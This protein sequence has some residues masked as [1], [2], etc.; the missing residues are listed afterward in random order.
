MKNELADR[1]EKKKKNHRECSTKRQRE[2]RHEREVET[3]YRMKGS[4]LYC[5]ERETREN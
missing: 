1:F 3:K 2:R 4:K 5:L